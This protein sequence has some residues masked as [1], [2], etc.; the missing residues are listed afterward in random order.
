MRS[1]SVVLHASVEKAHHGIT[2]LHV[3]NVCRNIF[4][5]KWKL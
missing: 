4:L 3:D 5:A 1:Y 2:Y